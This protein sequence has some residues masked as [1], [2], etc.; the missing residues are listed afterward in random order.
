MP[1][2]L[3]STAAG[4]TAD[5][6]KYV[7]QPNPVKTD[8]M[9][10]PTTLDFSLVNFD[11]GFVKLVRG[12]YIKAYSTIYGG[13]NLLLWSEDFTNFIWNASNLTITPNATTAPDGTLSADKIQVVAS[14]TALLN[15]T[16]AG[17][18]NAGGNTYTI[19][20]KQGSGVTDG[21][22]FVLRNVT[23]ATNL[24]S[25]TLNY[26]TGV[27]TQSIGSGATATSAANGFW[28]L[29][30]L[31]PT[32]ISQGNSIAVYVG[33]VGG[34]E[35]AGEFL[36][37]WGAQ[38]ETG[39]T[40]SIYTKTT[41]SASSP[42][43]T[44]YVINDPEPVY[45]GTKAGVQQFCYN[46]K[47]VSDE[48]I[49]NLETI[50]IIPPFINTD[51]GTVIKTLVNQLCPGIF[52]VTGVGAG[53]PIARLVVDP[54]FKF[55]DVVS[56]FT[57][58]ANHRFFGH[59]H[60][61]FFLPQDSVA[62]GLT[63]DGSNKHFTPSSLS[64][65]VSS[66]PV[67]NDSVVLGNIEPQQYMNEYFVSDGL[68]GSYPLASAIFGV[69]SSVFLDD[70]FSAS[71]IDTTKWNYFDTSNT[72]L[73][74]SNGYLNCLGGNNNNAFDVMLQSVALIPLE[75][76]LSMTHGE[77]DFLNNASRGVNGVIG[78][79][80]TQTPNTTDNQTFPGCFSGL[81]VYNQA[82]LLAFSEQFDNAIW[83]KNGSAGNPVVTAN[84]QTGPLGGLVADTIAFPVTAAGQETY[85]Q[86]DSGIVPTNGQQYTFS[87]WMKAASSVTA[88]LRIVQATGQND[89]VHPCAVTTAWQRFSMTVT[90]ASVGTGSLLAR[91][92]EGASTAAT[93]IF[94]FGAQLE[95]GATMT[96][97]EVRGGE[98][99][100]TKLMPII[101]GALDRTQ[102]VTVD[103]TKRYIIKTITNVV[104]IHRRILRFSYINAAGVVVNNGGTAYI[105]AAAIATVISEV[106]PTT[107]NLT[108]QTF[109]YDTTA[110]TSNQTWGIYVPLVSN[111]LHATVTGITVNSPL[112]AML[113]LAA[114][115]TLTWKQSFIG[116]NQMDA[117]DG[118]TPI[119][120]IT[121][122]NSGAQTS[123]SL[124][125]NSQY[126][127]GQAT[128][129]FF[130]NSANQT[131]TVPSVGT[132]MHLRYRRPGAA[133]ARVTDT[134]SQA[135]EATAWGDSGLRSSIR[136]DLQPVPRNSEECAWAAQAIVGDNNYQHY[137]GSYK[138]YSDFCTSEPQSGQILKFSNL[139]TGLPSVLQAEELNEVKTTFLSTRPE[140]FLHEVT[141]GK[142]DRLKRFLAHSYAQSD[143]FQIVDT[144]ETPAAIPWSSVGTAF[145]PDVIA[146]TLTSWDASNYNFNTN[147]APPGLSP[148]L[149][150]WTE[151]Y[152]NAV[153][154]KANATITA[155]ATTDP[156]GGSTADAVAYSAT[157][158]G[159]T[160]QQFLPAPSVAVANQTFTLSGW[161]KVA[162][163]TPTLNLLIE[164]QSFNVIANQ[165]FPIT[166]AW[167]RF[168]VTGTALS[169]ATGLR[170]FFYNPNTAT[171]YFIWGIQLE[172]GSSA[173][174]YVSQAG[175]FV[176]NGGF[177]VRYTDESW[178][179]DAGKNLV[180]R[181]TGST[182]TFAVPRN[183]R[184]KVCFA[185]A[186]DM[187]NK[188][189]WSEDITNAAWQ[190]LNGVPAPTVANATALNPDGDMS[191]ISTVTFSAAST[192]EVF[193][194]SVWP[195]TGA[196]AVFSVSLKGTAGQKVRV[197]LECEAS[198]FSGT[199]V[200]VTFTG[201][202][203]RVSVSTTGAGTQL[204]TFFPIISNAV[205]SLA[206]SFQM[207]RASLEI[208]T[209]S[210]TVYCKTNGTAYG[211][212]SQFAS[213]V[214]V[215]FPL[216]PATPSATINASDPLH[217]IVNV[218]LPVVMADVWGIEI[219]A[220]NNSTVL[221][222]RD[223][224]DSGYLAAVIADNSVAKSRSLSY[225]VYT[226]NLLGEYSTAFNVTASLPAPSASSVTTD[227]AT[228]RV[229]WNMTFTLPI[230]Q[231]LFE[232]ATDSGY[233]NIIYSDNG[234][235]VSG[236]L[237]LGP[238][239]FFP[240]RY[241][242][243]TP[244][245]ALGAG[246]AATG[247]HIYSPTGVVEFNG[248][249]VAVIPAPATPTTD[250]VVPTPLS[251][252]PRDIID[253]G[254]GNYKNNR[255]RYY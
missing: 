30:I 160:L 240:Q 15:Q 124:L 169:T 133:I 154:S 141:F 175:S 40:V 29:T 255:Y 9:N 173:T 114:P 74:V 248:N 35:T 73:Q 103:F 69:D 253:N 21:N 64:M 32:G 156:L 8:R 39:A 49:L 112:N 85:I 163:G 216:I 171:T 170:A 229:K 201:Q 238:A 140:R 88:N 54:T 174:A 20:V 82:N 186:F 60:K 137:E 107:G 136:K 159:S 150:L 71:T 37:A 41:S 182:Q 76:N 127:P 234:S 80:W 249:E 213:G 250:P 63:V 242:R 56:R 204:G 215:G 241:F 62:S 12:N 55:I 134:S 224:T 66:D 6:A 28:R 95:L 227:E 115:N 90:M 106:D 158:T 203:Q 123:S 200:D 220:S 26:S 168:S 101:N 31:A 81:R 17:A 42:W 251:D 209:T 222:H 120:T 3:I 197:R 53:L 118:V 230:V 211:A 27:I 219:R 10:E 245:D 84:T 108:N 87:C 33:F 11:A 144:T 164:D 146:P 132:F 100:V 79:M 161:V 97:Y 18:G 86:Q 202:W 192:A 57:D 38:L 89:T 61:L 191:Q 44:G 254:W 24:A 252:Y 152:T 105:D 218:G 225:F 142:V 208:N 117:L 177:E 145:A 99:L 58:G 4:T 172:L 45:L 153:W 231:T 46:Y 198:P 7:Y 116:P 183:T 221:Y 233:T 111:D 214:K 236:T 178:G 34:T 119:A 2:K 130:K 185:K 5:Y 143:T 223:L 47:A 48:Y 59:D 36:F 65:K 98:G 93:T 210:E 181:T 67:I 228:M 13:E 149:L 147:Q 139:P 155:N 179:S 167:Q 187:R 244:Y 1:L 190:K 217:P 14:S 94:V 151:D 110:L 135:V 51:M 189:L 206:K 235:G 162:S 25:I 212:V 91:L 19:Y 247:N 166:S 22:S 176:Y 77:W 199:N 122:A 226:Y 75:G 23:T 96:S 180:T 72:F 16:I 78:G 131:T 157:G 68:T 43:F 52:D 70:D 239:D 113:E 126:N 194:N 128:L 193:Q 92:H 121:D 109:F 138:Q 129:Q 83:T 196:T 102:W 246:T 148:N 188:L 207:T 243:V 195:C 125:G 165:S 232:I 237:L 205:D 184:G 104:K 50:G